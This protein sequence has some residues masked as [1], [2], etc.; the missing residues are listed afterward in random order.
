MAR[1]K[2][3]QSADGTPPRVRPGLFRRA[4]RWWVEGWW[5][6]PRKALFGAETRAMA[7]DASRLFGQLAADYRRWRRARRDSA[8][9]LTY[10]QMLAAWGIEA[11]DVPRM[12]LALRGARLRVGVVA[13]SAY[14]ALLVQL[15]FDRF[16][17]VLYLLLALVCVLALSTSTLV[18]TWR[19]HCLRTK[20]YRE[21]RSWLGLHLRI[22][23]R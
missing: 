21:F 20:R 8:P 15:V 1:S 9:V 22:F 23:R 3:A 17:S 10:R 7:A 6:V 14:G 18:L 5:A 4:G 13:A 2:H 11:P 16:N 19:L 12:L